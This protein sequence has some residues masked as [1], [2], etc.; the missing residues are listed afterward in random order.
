MINIAFLVQ[1]PTTKPLLIK[2][3]TIATSNFTITTFD[4]PKKP[5][6]WRTVVT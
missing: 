1:N 2:L 3:R 5:Q 6:K 4:S